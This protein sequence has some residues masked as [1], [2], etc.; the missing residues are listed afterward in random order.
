[1]SSGFNYSLDY[2]NL[3]LREEPHLYRVGKRGVETRPTE[4]RLAL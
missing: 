4:R 3:D 1:M 2:K